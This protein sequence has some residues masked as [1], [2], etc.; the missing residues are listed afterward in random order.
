MSDRQRTRFVRIEA[1][2]ATLSILA[3]LLLATVVAA[4]GIAIWFL[5]TVA[6]GHALAIHRG[7]ADAPVSRDARDDR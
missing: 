7:F 2:V 5:G 1:I 4:L 6:L 3:G